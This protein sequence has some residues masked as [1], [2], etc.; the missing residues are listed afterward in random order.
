MI[1]GASRIAKASQKIV[2]GSWANWLPIYWDY[3]KDMVTT[4]ETEYKI[5]DIIR[6]CTT[7]EVEEMIQRWR[8]M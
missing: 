2:Q 3:E 4:R 8:W 1:K 6:P 5:G 7:K